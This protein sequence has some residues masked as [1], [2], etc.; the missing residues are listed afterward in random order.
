MEEIFK[1]VEKQNDKR[2]QTEGLL[3]TVRY[4]SDYIF[5]AV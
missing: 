1:S 3:Q 5:S 2:F 4:Q